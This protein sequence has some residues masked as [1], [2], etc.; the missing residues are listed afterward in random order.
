MTANLFDLWLKRDVLMGPNLGLCCYEQ[1][2][3]LSSFLL[4]SSS[5]IGLFSNVV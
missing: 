5:A 3:T 4:G 2:G 1:C